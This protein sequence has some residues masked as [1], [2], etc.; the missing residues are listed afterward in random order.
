MTKGKREAILVKVTEAVENALR[1]DQK[2]QTS[3]DEK[4][5]PNSNSS[6]YQSGIPPAANMTESFFSQVH[7]HGGR[8]PA[9]S[10]TPTLKPLRQEGTEAK[11]QDAANTSKQIQPRKRINLSDED[12]QELTKLLYRLFPSY[13]ELDFL[14]QLAFDRPLAKIILYDTQE[15]ELEVATERLISWSWHRNNLR[16]LLNGALEW[17]PHDTELLN[18]VDHFDYMYKK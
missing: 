13:E 16:N 17:H 5:T 14:A 10:E 6:S 1:L 8:S 15:L 11:S 7:H 18:F 4:A 3:P 12:F 2:R 9:T